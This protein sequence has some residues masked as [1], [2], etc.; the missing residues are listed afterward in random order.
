MPNN[1][2]GWVTWI[3]SVVFS[4]ILGSLITVWLTG[5]QQRQK[6][7][8]EVQNFM[9]AIETEVQVLFEH[10]YNETGKYLESLKPEE[11]ANFMYLANQDYFSV[12]SSNVDKIGR[13]PKEIGQKIV[14]FYTK[15]RSL[16]D[17]YELN[18]KILLELEHWRGIHNVSRDL[19]SKSQMD[20]YEIA[21]RNNLNPLREIHYQTAIAAKEL[22][23]ALSERS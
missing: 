7:T 12:Y 10:Y 8:S 6:D 17:S 13:V 2:G 16:L 20:S 11:S 9:D 15:A 5:R 14:L 3:V 18:N 22:L 1:L 23:K 4:G 19:N 21:L